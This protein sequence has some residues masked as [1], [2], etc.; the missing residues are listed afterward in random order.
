MSKQM[1]FL[2]NPRGRKRRA[3]TKKKAVAKKAPARRRRRRT[4]AAK[5]AAPVRRKKAR[6]TSAGV[7][8]WVRD[9]GFTSWPAYMESIRGGKT[10]ARRRR[11]SSARKS[12]APARRRRRRSV[13]AAAPRRRRRSYRRNPFG[14]STSGSGSI[15]AIATQGAKDA[16]GIIV[17]ETAARLVRGRVGMEG[18][19]IPAA[20]VETVT[21]VAIAVAIRKKFPGMARMVAAGAIAGPMRTAIKSAHLPYVSAA[22]GD[23]GELPLL[24]T[25]DLGGEY[26]LGTGLGDELGAY[27]NEAGVYA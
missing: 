4:V 22:L 12:A 2:V 7:P 8:Q 10:V 27:A 3:G 23:E 1:Q 9:K 15:V 24:G 13:T 19:T 25:Y 11:K 26:Q 5:R 21:G 6:R 17:G 20:V 14:I 18:N 16:A